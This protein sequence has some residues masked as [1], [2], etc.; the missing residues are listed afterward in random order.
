MIDRANSKLEAGD[1]VAAGQ[2]LRKELIV[3]RK[4]VAAMKAVTPPPEDQRAMKQLLKVAGQLNAQRSL[5]VQALLD[6]DIE[7]VN[8]V[9]GTMRTLRTKRIALGQAVGACAH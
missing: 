2:I 1:P 9:S 4:Y 3:E 6:D 5:L 8:S 7:T